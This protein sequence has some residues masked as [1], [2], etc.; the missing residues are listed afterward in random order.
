M[1]A[2]LRAEEFLSASDRLIACVTSPDRRKLTMDGSLYGEFR[3]YFLKLFTR[4]PG[5]SSAQFDNY[6][7]DFLRLKA[8]EAASCEVCITKEEI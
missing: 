8:T 2:E 1:A 5:Q 4:E 3:D 7:V 6:L